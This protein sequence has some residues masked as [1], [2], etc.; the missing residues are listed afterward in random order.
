VTKPVKSAKSNPDSPDL[1]KDDRARTYSTI[2]RME[3]EY[4]KALLIL[5][6]L[7][8]SATSALLVALWG[9]SATISGWAN[10]CLFA[11]WIVWLLGIIATLLSFR[12]S[13]ALNRRV[14]E[15][16]VEDKL[17][18]G[19]DEAIKKWDGRNTLATHLS[20]FLFILGVILAASFIAIVCTTTTPNSAKT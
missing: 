5:H 11:S 6:P 18:T 20:G 17:P 16:L 13:I 8:I 7:G 1:Y 4:D 15:L 2:E 12:F 9:R 10:A 3:L 19:N 14:L